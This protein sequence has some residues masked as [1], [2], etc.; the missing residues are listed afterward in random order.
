MLPH[1]RWVQRNKVKKIKK[2]KENISY[3]FFLFWKLME[4]KW[5]I[6]N[7]LWEAQ[8]AEVQKYSHYH[9]LPHDSMEHS[10]STLQHPWYQPAETI[11]SITTILKIKQ[12]LKTAK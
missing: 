8:H 9:Q 10:H 11:S 1:R 7:N 6:I 12:I 2:F 3:Y 4:I 5:K